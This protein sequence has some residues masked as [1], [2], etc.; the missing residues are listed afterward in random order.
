MNDCSITEC[1][2]PVRAR[3]WCATHWMRWSQHGDPLTGS[4]HV[5]DR[6]WAK[7]QIEEDCW[8]WSGHLTDGYGKFMWNHRQGQA[9]RFAYESFVGPIPEGLT[10]DHLCRN[11]ACVNPAHMEPVTLAVNGLRGVSPPATNARKTDCK[12][13]HPLS[14]ENLIARPDGRECRECHRRLCREYVH[15]N[16]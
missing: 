16:S 11:R 2:K 14:G 10:I 7:V 13:G 6:F 5:A 3:G 12:W 9:H 4:Q 1:S 8:V 15:R